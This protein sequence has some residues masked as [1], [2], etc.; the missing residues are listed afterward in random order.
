VMGQLVAVGEGRLAPESFERRWRQQRRSEVKE[1]AP[2]QGL[3]LLR[4]GYPQEIF[5]RAA[6][7]DC[8][9]RYQLATADPPGQPAGQSVP[10][11]PQPA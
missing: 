11:G 7:Y 4:V 5:P 9:P 8:Q 10:A 6:W 3:C 2:P 1:A